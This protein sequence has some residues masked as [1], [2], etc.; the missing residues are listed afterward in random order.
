MK[1]VVVYESMFGS[2]GI[3]G[4]AIAEGLREAGDVRVGTVDDVSPDDVRDA[5]LLVAGGPTHSRGM[6]KADARGSISKGKAFAKYGPVLA[7]RE[8]LDGWLERLPAGDATVVTFDT[9]FDRAAWLTGSA[10]KE[11][12]RR[13]GGKGYPVAEQ[14]SFFVRTTGG[15]L[16]DGE[17]ERAVA[18][19]R[20]LAADRSQVRGS[21]DLAR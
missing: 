20:E 19:G 7:G 15:P 11:I 4:E 10:A 1:V 3:I 13:L 8:S 14:R 2:T 6:A 5:S 21:A 18:W 12:A 9:R 16:A 17:R